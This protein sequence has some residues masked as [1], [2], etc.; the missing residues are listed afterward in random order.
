MLASVRNFWYV[1]V[2]DTET[3]CS[4]YYYE[5]VSR[6]TQVASSKFQLPS[7]PL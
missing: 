6:G 2:Q 3:G 5:S 4:K 1:L 7:S